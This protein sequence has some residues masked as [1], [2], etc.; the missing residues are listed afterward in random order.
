[1]S[2]EKNY[3]KNTGEN[4]LTQ[5]DTMFKVAIKEVLENGYMSGQARPKYKSTG[6]TAHSKYKT[7]VLFKYNI[8]NNEFPVTT[9]RRIPIKTGIKEM[10]WFYQE[11]SNDLKLL[12]D[13]YNVHYWDDWEVDDSGTIGKR[14]GATV[15]EY[16]IMDRILK[17]LEENP[18]NRRMKL[19]L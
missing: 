16:G 15:K 1:M 4:K 2:P 18:W 17:G 6:K 14:Y 12:K 13:K 7:G 9:L 10:L 5:V 19:V 3:K 8:A 11:Q